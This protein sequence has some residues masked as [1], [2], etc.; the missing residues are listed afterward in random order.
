MAIK[1]LVIAD[2]PMDF[3]IAASNL[4]SWGFEVESAEG[5]ETAFQKFSSFAPDL[6]I[7]DTELSD[8]SG[9]LFIKEFR[10]TS[11]FEQV[12]IIYMS[13]DAEDTTYV[14]ALSSGA[15]DFIQKPL[16][17]AE[18]SLKVDKELQIINYKRK[19]EQANKALQKEVHHLEKYFPQEIVE[20]I[21]SEEI[22]ANLGGSIMKASIVFLDLRNSTAMAEKTDPI[23]FATFISLVFTDL[24]DLVFGLQGSVNKLLGDGILATFGCPVQRPNDTLNSVLFAAKAREWVRTVNQMKPPYITEDIG[25][26]IGICTGEVF[27][28]NVGSFRRMEYTV[29]GDPVNS[30]SRLQSMTKRLKTEIL[31]DENTKNEIEG[32]FHTEYAGSRKIRGKDRDMKIYKVLEEID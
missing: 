24:M 15:D 11:S 14:L 9:I 1:I 28:G 25:I 13:F 7:V 21:V 23:Q 27:A 29:M 26:G 12:P 19:I 8:S 3:E 31:I 10:N 6:L 32:H 20:K 22:T 17:P 16:R 18:L 2:N 30:A 5:K 4:E